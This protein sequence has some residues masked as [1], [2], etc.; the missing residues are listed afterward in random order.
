MP[1]MSVNIIFERTTY[2]KGEQKTFTNCHLMMKREIF[3]S[4][5]LI[6]FCAALHA[7]E[8]SVNTDLDRDYRKGMELL[9]QEKYAAAQEKFR[10]AIVRISQLPAVTSHD[11]LIHAKYYDALCSKELNRPDAEKLFSDLIE[12]NEI[13]ATVRRAYFQLGNI[14]FDQKKYN[15]A[16]PK[17]RQVD[18]ADLSDD[19]K[20]VYDFRLATCYFY[21]KDFDKARPV[22]EKLRTTQNEY[23]YPAN[24]Y[25]AYI[26]YKQGDFQSALKSFRIAGQSELY[27]PVVPYYLANIRFMQHDYDGVISDA[28]TLTASSSPYLTEMQQLVGKS[29]FE[30]GQYEKALPYFTAFLSGTQKISKADLYQI[31]FCQYQTKE[32]DEAIKTLEQLTVLND[33]LGQ[34]AL[35]LLADCYVKTDRKN[36][37]RLAFEN[38]AKMN[39]DSFVQEQSAFQFAKLSHEL[40]Y[41][42]VS[43]K[44][45]QQFIASYPKSAYTEDAKQFLTQEF[46]STSNYRDA[47]EVIKS[48]SVK[49]PEMRRAYQKVAFSRAT[50]LFNEKK[51]ADANG[52][53]DESLTNPVD[54]ALQAAA[55]FWKGE[56]AYQLKD[57]AS[58]I[59]SHNQFQ[60]LLKSGMK[61]PK[62]VTKL[63]SDYT[64]GYSYLGQEAYDKAGASFQ[65]VK[66]A[67]AAAATEPSKSIYADA[68]LR[69]GDCSFMTRSY[70]NAVSSY[71]AVITKKLTGADYAMYQKSVILGLQGKTED[72]IAL[73]KS[74]SVSYP[75]SIYSDDA[76]F[77]LGV[78]YLSIPSYN[79]AAEAFNRVISK[80]PTGSY[81]VKSHLKLGLIFFN[82]DNNKNA[83]EEY[84]TVLTKYPNSPE[85]ADALNGVKEVFTANGDAQGYVNFVKSVPNINISDATQDSV[86]YLAA[87]ANYSKGNCSQAIT[88]FGNYL[89]SFPQGAF[90]L[91][92]HFYRAECL[93]K[94]ADYNAALSDYEFVA[95]QS[96]SRFSAKAMLQAARIN[97]NP[98]K[99]YGKAFAYYQQVSNNAELKA[100]ALEAA[101][102]MMY[103]AYNLQHNQEVTDAANRILSLANAA[104]E[105]QTE[106]HFYL[107]RVA[108]AANDFDKAFAEFS[109][110][111]K[112]SSGAAG[113]EAAYRIADIYFS[114]NQL[115][116][117]EEQC[118]YVVKS[119]SS[120]DYWIAKS[121]L[122]MA[123]VFTAQGDLFQAKATLQSIIDNYK[124][125]DD[126]IP[127][128]N[129]KLEEVKAKE[130]EKSKL[131]PDEQ[132]EDSDESN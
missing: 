128:A 43:V 22:F 3:C 125:S 79:E 65:S 83:L 61:L 37:A 91:H 10:E 115:K 29:Y 71:D 73:L 14:Y 114:R 47:L 28:A 124:G 19:E 69:S 35:Y 103:C 32:Y 49:S 18:P 94:N 24:Y 122:L 90:A 93:F 107:G 109:A 1:L 15:K 127:A 38:A 104:A 112:A 68:L 25:Y 27:K 76:L 121:Y 12:E 80:Y 51:Y 84:R 5:F 23:Y 2:T 52:L 74:L 86:A 7:Q 17:Y 46:L 130:A 110:V 96:P 57:Y 34:N 116:Q 100:D 105:D 60:D 20:A 120:Q 92:A 88:E 132:K 78:A 41:H 48:L 64:L 101:K 11:L 82:L 72:K 6:C 108:F 26:S 117:T 9:Q 119:K 56:C 131:L 70:G 118:W 58:A 98:K 13:N 126:I 40:N 75:S 55:Y 81:V 66:T 31:G 30:N 53:L 8:T 33:S 50:E 62:D 21:Q 113:A 16:L 44:A 95:D 102:G 63:N 123:D 59:E 97:Y 4:L 42:D 77:E 87:E 99:D 36:D 54:P 89:K 67:L 129:K 85:R 39:F 106:A 45:L 111:S